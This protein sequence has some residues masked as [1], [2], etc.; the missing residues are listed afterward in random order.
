MERAQMIDILK[1]ASITPERIAH[2]A[3]ASRWPCIDVAC[4]ICNT[5][6][7]D[8][9][10]G[11]RAADQNRLPAHPARMAAR[12]GFHQRRAALF[13][14]PIMPRSDLAAAGERI[15]H[16]SHDAGRAL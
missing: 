12:L 1:L 11:A 2:L 5:V 16:A 3:L 15:M 14:M 10:L 4:E 13:G 7:R 9:M 6:A 8:F